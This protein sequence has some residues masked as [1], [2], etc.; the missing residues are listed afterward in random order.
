MPD[1]HVDDVRLSYPDAGHSPHTHPA[2]H[3][4]AVTA[5]AAA[6]LVA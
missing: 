6:A 2:E 1:L 4:A 3:V 5:F